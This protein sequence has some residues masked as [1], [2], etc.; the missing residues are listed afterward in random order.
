MKTYLL[1]WNPKRWQWDNIVQMSTDV[2]MGNHV[3][4]RW[5]SGVSKRPRM[6]D[7]FFLIRLG[8]E[9]K[10]IFASGKIMRD[11]FEALHWDAEKSSLGETTNYVEIKYDTLLNPD[12]DPILPC[13]FLNMPHSQKCT[14]ILKCLESKFQTM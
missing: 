11:T 4:D 8:E 10:G 2:K 1:A 14:G 12:V 3:L 5:S 13:D 6:G 9:P 7:R